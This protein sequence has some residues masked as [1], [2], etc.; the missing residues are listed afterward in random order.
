MR[1]PRTMNS[2]YCRFTR[3]WYV[4]HWLVNSQN[5][6]TEIS[7]GRSLSLVTLSRQYSNA[8]PRGTKYVASVAIPA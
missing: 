8:W 3:S 5:E 2:E 4:S 1:L 6:K 7:R